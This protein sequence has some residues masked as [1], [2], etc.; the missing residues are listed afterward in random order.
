LLTLRGYRL[1][2]ITWNVPKDLPYGKVS[3][4]VLAKDAAGNKSR[5]CMP[6]HVH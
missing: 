2:T 5:R 4:C 3:F 1:F 6:L